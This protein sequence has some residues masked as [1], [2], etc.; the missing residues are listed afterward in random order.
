[1]FLIIDGKYYVFIPDVIYLYVVYD[2]Y[3]LFVMF[4][5]TLK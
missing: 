3:L 2:K 1:M 5:L 4:L